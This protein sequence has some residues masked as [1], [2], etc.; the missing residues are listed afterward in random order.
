MH[1]HKYT[2]IV[3]NRRSIKDS[4]RF[5]TLYTLESGKIDVYARSVRSFK[6][7]R[8]ASL[9]LFSHI[10][11]DVIEKNGRLTLTHVEL[12]H[13][14]QESKKSLHNISRLFQIGELIDKLTALEDPHPEVYNLLV[15]AL[16]N[17]SRFETLDYMTRFKKKLLELLGYGDHQDIDQD[18]Y[19][20]TLLT[21]PLRSRQISLC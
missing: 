13:S 4:D 9:D 12:L 3:I 10:K 8:S 17:L 6:S 7:K 19:I 21:K 14:H 20:D 5:I 1:Y 18:A 2:A 11:C 15:L 16:D